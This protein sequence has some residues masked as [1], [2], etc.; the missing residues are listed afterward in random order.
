MFVTPPPT[1]SPDNEYERDPDA[2]VGK[3]RVEQLYDSDRNNQQLESC[4]APY[5]GEGTEYGDSGEKELS[6]TV[7]EDCVG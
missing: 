3:K 7:G 1:K 6:G 5:E 2:V 4:P